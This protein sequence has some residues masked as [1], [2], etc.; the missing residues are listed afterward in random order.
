MTDLTNT[1]D[2]KEHRPAGGAP[3]GA[4]GKAPGRGTG[5]AD[6]RMF[7]PVAFVASCVGFALIG[8]LQSFYGPSIPALRA[9]FGLSPA[10]A[11]VGLTAHFI[12]GVIGVLAFN[13]VHDRVGNRTLLG[14]S[15]AL[16]AVG[17]LG[18][19]YASAWPP[20]L[21]AAFFAGLGFGGIDYGLNQLVA[22]GF[23][24]RSTAMLN[25]LNAFFGIG[26]VAG[27]VLIGVLG[28]DRYAVAFTACGV[29]SA[30]LLLFLRGVGERTA[31]P[32]EAGP[33]PGTPSSPPARTRT[34]LLLAAFVALYVLHVGV[35]AGVGGWEPTHLQTV[36]YGAAFAAS[37]TSVF[38]LMMTVGRFLVVPL[39][40][41]RPDHLIIKVSCA[42]MA[43]CLAAATVP[44][45]AP[46]MYAGVGLFIA[47]VFPT[48]LP[49]LTRTVPLA[50]RASA[51]VIA[52]SMLGGVAAGPALGA[53][54]QWAGARSVP[55]VLCVI[56][57]MCL[58]TSVWIDRRTR[59]QG[60][61]ASVPPPRASR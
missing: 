54:I 52:A 35:E 40:L 9:E 60:V 59:R 21:I 7:T 43:V 55:L 31:R 26:A 27:P 17:S 11:G 13:R 53:M 28:A 46:F 36:G 49:W 42:G 29:L 15:Y 25:V 37:A 14:V 41:R 50:R 30:L 20:A 44:A 18:F 3:P 58:G 2:G 56:S 6:V 23:G 12:G 57:V 47:P 5:T 33:A 22:V 45:L 51:H 32:P 61:R 1:P 48:G 34:W 4:P 10:A 8:A 24:D 16:M 39:T 38:W 19:A